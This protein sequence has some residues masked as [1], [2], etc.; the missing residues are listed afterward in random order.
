MARFFLPKENIHDRC[1]LIRGEELNHLRKVLRL[2]AGDAITVF[3]ESGWEHEAVI[4]SVNTEEAEIDIHRS[5]AAERESPIEITLALGLTKADKMDFVIEK[6]TELG[7]HTIAPLIT[8]FTVPNLDQK[9]SSR[10]VDRWEKIALSATKQSGR[11]RVPGIR[12][13]VAFSEFIEQRSA[14]DLNLLFWEKEG[15]RTLRKLNAAQTPEHAVTIAVGPEGGFSAA[16]AQAA[17]QRGFLTVSLGPRILRAETAPIAALA[18][19]QF[20]WGDLG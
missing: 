12:P 13:I 14:R 9:K 4:R 5:H 20:L 7:V 17:L 10:R 1:G 19:V 15:E 3:D 16:E 8:E 18:L 2:R 6:A 11:T